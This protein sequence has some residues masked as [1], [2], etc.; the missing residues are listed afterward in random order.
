M[1]L[2]KTHV[3]TDHHNKEL[4][5]YMALEVSWIMAN[6]AHGPVEAIE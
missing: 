1:I 6:I 2:N 5:R 4:C 3:A